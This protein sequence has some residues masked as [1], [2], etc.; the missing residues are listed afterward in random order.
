MITCQEAE[1]EHIEWACL[2]CVRTLNGQSTSTATSLAKPEP[3]GVRAEQQ[4]WGRAGA[5]YV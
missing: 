1:L 3:R 5:H 2:Q 4:A